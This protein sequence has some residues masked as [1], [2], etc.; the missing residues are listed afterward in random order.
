MNF[1]KQLVYLEVLFLSLLPNNINYKISLRVSN[2]GV[3][4]K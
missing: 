3:L 2:E 1:L 4:L